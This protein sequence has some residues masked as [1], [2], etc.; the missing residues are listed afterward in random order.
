M[1]GYITLRAMVVD[2]SIKAGVIWGGVVGSYA[3]ICE[4]WFRCDDED[5]SR[6]FARRGAMAEF[7]SPSHN[8]EFWDAASATTFLTG[9]S[10]PLQLHHGTADTT[11]PIALARAQ[12]AFSQSIGQT[13]E[14]YEYD[15][16]NHNISLSFLEAV[17]HSVY[18]FALHVKGI[19]P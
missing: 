12:Y 1:G 2:P 5:N 11:V 7:G 10:A 19:Q 6:N 17:K 13:V 15:G 3:D 9:D 16:D 14:L 4:F 8:P 18:F